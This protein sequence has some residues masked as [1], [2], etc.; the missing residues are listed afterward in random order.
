[1][2]K[3]LRLKSWL[4]SFLALWSGI[5]LSFMNLSL[6]ISKMGMCFVCMHMHIHAYT[7]VKNWNL[8]KFA[9]VKEGFLEEYLK[10]DNNSTAGRT[11]RTHASRNLLSSIHLHHST[12]IHHLYSCIFYSLQRGFFLFIMTTCLKIAV[13]SALSPFSFFNAHLPCFV[14]P[15]YLV[16]IHG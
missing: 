12:L 9:H 16:Q 3:S 14:Q 13:I 4:C 5:K 6:F 2:A 11:V 15:L 10:I 7:H 8:L 1:M